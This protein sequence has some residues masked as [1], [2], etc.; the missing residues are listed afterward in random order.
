MEFQD[1]INLP[2]VLD[3]KAGEILREFETLQVES[4]ITLDSLVRIDTMAHTH[5]LERNNNLVG[6]SIGARGLM[7]LENSIVRLR[8]AP[9]SSEEF[10]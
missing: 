1:F 8:Q 9:L 6:H 10:I 2:D 7:S 4:V 5:N 3:K